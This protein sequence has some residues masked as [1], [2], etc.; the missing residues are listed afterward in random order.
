MGKIIILLIGW[1]QK[2]PLRSHSQCVFLPTCSEYTKEAVSIHG[3][4][5]GLFLGTKR[6]LRCHPWQKGGYDG[7]PL[8]KE[9]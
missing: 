2:I 3:P 5:K 7:V 8:K 1:Y 6:I 4:Y 9:L